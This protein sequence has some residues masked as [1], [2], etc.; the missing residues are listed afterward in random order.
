MAEVW[1]L[2]M[3]YKIIK[4][5]SLS[6]IHPPCNHK[7]GHG[8]D[9]L[10]FVFYLWAGPVRIARSANSQTTRILAKCD[11]FRPWKKK[12]WQECC[13]DN[14][15]GD[16]RGENVFAASLPCLL[17]SRRLHPSKKKSRRLQVR[18]CR[19]ANSSRDWFTPYMVTVNHYWFLSFDFCN[20]LSIILMRKY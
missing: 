11:C 4:A 2:T 17:P 6:K 12:G 9:C 13:R 7:N 1:K 20:Y 14:L 8:L 5:F 10:D 19:Q 15:S 3:T 18:V 16:E